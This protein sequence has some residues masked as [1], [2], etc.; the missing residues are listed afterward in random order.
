MSEGIPV[1]VCSQCGR[2]YFP[3]RLACAACGARAFDDVTVG[4][5]TI[6]A[7]TLVHRAPGR[8][9]ETP[10]RIADVLLSGGPRVVAR[11]DVAAQQSAPVR[12]RMEGGGPIAG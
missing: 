5:G 12:L 3:H 9:L 11:V 10:V 8:S 7:A 2:R 1:Q 6:E 4:E